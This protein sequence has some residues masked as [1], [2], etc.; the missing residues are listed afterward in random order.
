MLDITLASEVSAK[1]KDVLEEENDKNAV[2]RIY[3]A[4][5]GAA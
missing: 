3:E 4:K 5:V 2:F 1:F